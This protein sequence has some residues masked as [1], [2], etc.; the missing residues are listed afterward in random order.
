MGYVIS[1]ANQKGGVG[2]TTTVINL[3]AALAKLGK[4]VLVIDL[5]YQTNASIGFGIPRELINNTSFDLLKSNCEV[6]ECTYKTNIDFVNII[7][8]SSDEDLI[9]IELSQSKDKEKILNTKILNFKNNYDYVIIDC[10][11]NFGTV[12]NN[13][14]YASDS[15]IIPVE[16]DYFAYDSLTQM[17]NKINQIQKIKNLNNQNLIIEGILF[18]K[19]DK[20]SNF[21]ET[22]VNKVKELFPIRT[23]N[24]II[25]RSVDFQ[26]APMY[27]K[28]IIEYDEK[29]RGSLEYISLANEILERNI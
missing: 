8:S 24:T 28:S 15:V 12:T 14:L 1:I 3:S 13:A 18:T 17:I 29:S 6:N 16:C 9:E 19:F 22:I 5:D 26:E 2:K 10:P 23:F 11:H 4:K 20:R 25:N 27:G 21:G 7:P